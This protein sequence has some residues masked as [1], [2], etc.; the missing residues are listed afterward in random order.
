MMVLLEQL[1]STIRMQ[2]FRGVS[3]ESMGTVSARRRTDK[4]DNVA[5]KCNMATRTASTH[6][7][8]PE[9]AGPGR[10]VEGMNLGIIEIAMLKRKAKAIRVRARTQF[11]DTNIT[12]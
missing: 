1:A 3:P 9:Q 5:N 8:S 11:F 12:E 10:G 2:L 4:L 7:P 6:G